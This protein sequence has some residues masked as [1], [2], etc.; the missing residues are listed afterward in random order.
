MKALNIIGASALSA[1]ALFSLFAGLAAFSDYNSRGCPNANQCSDAMTVMLMA[2]GV[3]IFASIFA[4]MLWASRPS[5]NRR[6][7]GSDA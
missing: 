3:T 5:S 7:S 2:G 4:A 1:L 6:G